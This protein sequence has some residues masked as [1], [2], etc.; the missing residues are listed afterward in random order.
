MIPPMLNRLTVYTGLLFSVMLSGIPCYPQSKTIENIVFEGAGIRGIAYGGVIQVMEENGKMDGI[1]KCGGTSAG[2]ITAL[3]ISI[4]YKSWEINEIIAGTRFETFNDGEYLFI[5]G[6]TRLKNRYGWYKGDEF[7]EWLGKIIEK[8]TGNADISFRELH[9]KGYKDLY[10]TA[11][12]LNQQRL[13][14]FSRETYPAMKIKDAVRISMSIPLYFEAVFIDREGKV[15][16]EQ[17]LDGNLDIVV[18]GG[19]IGNFPIFLFDSTTIG[20]Q[21]EM[22]RIPNENTLGVRIDSDQQIRSD[23]ATKELAPVRITSISDYLSA[24]YH[25]VLENLNRSQLIPADWDRT[26]SVSNAGMSPRIKKLTEEEKNKLIRAGA[27]AAKTYF[28]IK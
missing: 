17:N 24:F 10:I 5:G 26:I 15:Y 22:I 21:A 16:E 8:K 1:K 4:G 25:I 6:M 14:V 11:T 12:C 13:L 18:D 9:E 27:T 19:I 23:S 3:M 20:P 28:Q 2:A 7:T